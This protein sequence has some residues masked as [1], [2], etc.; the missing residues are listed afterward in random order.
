M[1]LPWSSLS[2]RLNRGSSEAVLLMSS[3]ICSTVGGSGRLGSTTRFFPLEPRF[4]MTARCTSSYSIC[5]TFNTERFNRHKG[6]VLQHN[7]KHFT[8]VYNTGLVGYVLIGVY[9]VKT[10]FSHIY[11]MFNP[12]K[13]S[14]I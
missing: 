5:R 6:T 14:F 1:A 12:Q 13:T 3:R 4:M 7:D 2:K 10:Y 8:L 9:Y 11:T